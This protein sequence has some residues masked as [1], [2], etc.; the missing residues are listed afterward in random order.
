MTNRISIAAAL[1]VAA[2][3]TSAFAAPI[4]VSTVGTYAPNPNN[5]TIRDAGSNTSA[6]G[7]TLSTFRTLITTAFAANLGGVVNFDNS[8]G[9]A[10]GG[11][12]GENAANAITAKFGTSQVNSLDFY[13]T[14]G[15]VGG[16]AI[17]PSDN[18]TLTLSG[19]GVLGFAFDSQPNIV[20]NQGLS[21][22]GLSLVPRPDGGTRSATLVAVLDNGTTLTSTLEGNTSQSDSVFFG[23]LAP[24][25]R[26]IVG[27]D[28][29]PNGFTRFDD[30]GFV[31]VPEPASLGLLGLGGLAM[32][33]RRRA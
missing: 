13:R 7:V 14:D 21:S 4:T 5:L 9:F 11:A 32:L 16:S 24:A 20:F 27:L 30:L 17:G 33:R 8:S 12:Y 23:F 31:V 22:L 10:Y 18:G 15:V 29:N 1:T 3:A 26:T 25:G 19:T 28:I 2:I 6:T